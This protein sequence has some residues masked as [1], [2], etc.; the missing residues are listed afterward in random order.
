[1][2]A[3]VARWLVLIGVVLA[4]A[5]GEQRSVQ[6]WLQEAQQSHAHADRAMEAGDAAE[7][8]RVLAAFFDTSAPDAINKDDAR[9]V[10]QDICYR[11]ARIALGEEAPEDAAAWAE[12]GL[13]QGRG[14]D[15]FT[16]NLYVVRGQAKEALG[17]AIDAAADYH[18]ALKINDQLLDGELS[19]EP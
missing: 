7:A 12:R 3:W 17:N 11:L 19:G 16:A 4:A 14:E 2:R 8:T 5:C 10:R 18:E 13:N 6:D 9:V 15:V 1:M